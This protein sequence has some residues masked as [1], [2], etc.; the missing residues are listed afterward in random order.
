LENL[1]LS[2]IVTIFW[3]IAISLVGMLPMR[4]HW[5][6]GLPMLCLFPVVLI[7]LGW[8]MG[9]WWAVGL[10]AGGVSIYRYPARHYGRKLLARLRGHSAPPTRTK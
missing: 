1:N 4:F 2:L 7:W 9:L 10:L 8:S 3:I 6:L 5:R